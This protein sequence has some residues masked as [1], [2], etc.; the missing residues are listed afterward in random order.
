MS[1]TKHGLEEASTA[2]CRTA[3]WRTTRLAAL[4]VAATLTLAT[5][6]ACTASAS[7]TKKPIKIGVL[8]SKTG[9]YS[10]LSLPQLAA[11]NLAVKQVNASGGINGSKVELVVD[12]DQSDPS[13]AAAEARTLAR[14]VKVVI[15]DSVGALCRATQP[16]FEAAGDFQF[17][18]SPQNFTLTPLFF[19]GFSNVNEYPGVIAKWFESRKVAKIGIIEENDATGQ[20][21]AEIAQAAVKIDTSAKVVSTQTFQSGS[22]N[23]EPQ[24]LALRSAG[25]DLIFTCTS[26]SNLYPIITGMDSLGM[27]QPVY[28][29]SGSVGSVE[30][31][32]V[33]NELPRGGMYSNAYWIDVASNTRIPS[34][35]SYAANIRSFSAAWKKAYHSIP[36]FNNAGPYDE[37]NEILRAM[38]NKATTPKAIANYLETH[39]YT[40]VLGIYHYSK[41]LHQGVGI[42]A[43]ML[44]FTRSGIFTLGYAAPGS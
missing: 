41:T 28:V 38:K 44:R 8:L 25:A 22:T 32:Q 33:K 43:I 13:T 11:L 23:V 34:S 6:V 40:G 39:N 18:L 2:R 24:L 37:L 29:S 19:W 21:N 31:Q 7:V 36:S 12:D 3:V 10:S 26:G 42:P 1:L 4:F 35:L 20:L 27:D 15:G 14:E 30:A 16:I 5:T 9:T 17:C